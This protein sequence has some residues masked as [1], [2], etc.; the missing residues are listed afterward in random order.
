VR[1]ADILSASFDDF[2]QIL[3]NL[4]LQIPEKDSEHEH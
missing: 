4:N 1:Q 2:L 3:R